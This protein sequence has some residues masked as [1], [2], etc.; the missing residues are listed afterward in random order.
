MTPLAL[1]AINRNMLPH[2]RQLC[3]KRRKVSVLCFGRTWLIAWSS[4]LMPAKGFQQI[5]ADWGGARLIIRI[6][7]GWLSRIAAL[8]MQNEDITYVFELP[9]SLRSIVFEA[10]FSEVANLIERSTRKRFGVVAVDSACNIPDE[11]TGF[12]FALDDG[13]STTDIELWMDDLGLAF[14]SAEARTIE[15]RNSEEEFWKS[16]PFDIK[17]CIGWTMISADTFK[18]IEKN[19]V[20]LLDECWIKDE[21]SIKLKLGRQAIIDAEIHESRIEITGNWG[22]C[23]D[24]TEEGI[25]SEKILGDL[26]IRISFDLGERVLTLSEIRSIEPGYVFELGRDLR[27]SVAVRANGKLIAEGELVDI[28]G[29]TGVSILRFSGSQ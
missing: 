17:F 1:R 6:E 23:V 25:D 20:I 8:V 2:F 7:S 12:L 4:L 24:D 29:Q 22:W 9:E 13:D 18:S 3:V 27:R 26:D 15:T 5:T 11:M 16:L 19:D 14:F 10:F 28:D 21:K